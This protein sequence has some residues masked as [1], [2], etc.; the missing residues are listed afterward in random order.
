MSKQKQ[1][2]PT[3]VQKGMIGLMAVAWTSLLLWLVPEVTGILSPDA[4][5]TYSEWV[6]DLPLW[7]ILCIAVLHVIA[8]VLFIWSAG[9]FLEGWSARR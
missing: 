9:H 3:K 2:A 6:W 1:V 8:G 4:E 5:D 7:A